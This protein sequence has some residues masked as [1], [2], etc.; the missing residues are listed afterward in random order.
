MIDKL[1]DLPEHTKKDCL[2]FGINKIV[3]QF[4]G[5]DDE[6]FLNIDISF[7]EGTKLE[8]YQSHQLGDLK[9]NLYDWAWQ[10]YSYSGAGV[11]NR[12][13]DNIT[14]DLENDTKTAERW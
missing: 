6:G 3:L 11:G 9:S 5:G 14:Y 2:K 12:Y 10:S 8:E 13:G 7:K 4:E 1:A